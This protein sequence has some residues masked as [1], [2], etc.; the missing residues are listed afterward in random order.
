[1]GAELGAQV[2]LERVPLKYA[3]LSYTEIWISEAQERMVLAVEP[4]RWGQLKALCD[5]ED[6][7]ATVIGRFTDD[8]RL[9]LRYEGQQVGQ[10][11]MEFLHHGLPMYKRKAVWKSPRLQEPVLAQGSDYTGD[12]LAILSSYNVAS[13]EWVIRQYD[14]EVQAGSVVKPLTGIANDGPSDAAVVRPRLDSNR[15]VA[16]ACGMNPIYGQIDPY[17]MAVSAIDE[18]VRNLICVGARFDRIALLDNFCWADCTRPEVLGSLV[19][20]AQGCYDGAI[21]FG[22]PFISGKD[23]LYNQFVCE[24]GTIISIPPTLL[25]SG[26]AIVD[27]ADRCITMDLK[28]PGNYIFVVGLTA[29]ELGGSHYY[30]IKGHLGANVP[31]VDLEVAPRIAARLSE[32]IRD[33]LVASCHDCSEGGLAVA[34]A[35]MA[36][37]GGLGVEVDLEGLPVTSDANRPDVKL[38]SE[39]N[40]R[41]VVEVRPEH[42]DAFARRVLN[43]PFGLIGR[44]VQTKR[45]VVRD[46][47]NVVVD[48]DIEVLK[49]AWKRPLAWD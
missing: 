29:N 4:E 35:E 3:G 24:D 9:V 2:D 47:A 34:I 22:S 20:A 43:L 33:G 46:G 18:A 13:K 19:R 25:I 26:L 31:K 39:S 44:V 38:F 27:Q 21:A 17:W 32:A 14:H 1:M 15:A 28:A 6:V 5:S 23:S 7:E 40:S 10:L 45:M 37:A 42:F 11:D 48:A 41:Y 49:E 12:L 36:F 8:K 30:K 16:I